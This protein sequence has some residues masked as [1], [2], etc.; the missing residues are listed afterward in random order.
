MDKVI[1]SILL[2]DPYIL[3]VVVRQGAVPCSPVKPMHTFSIDMLEL[4]RVA[5][6]RNPHFSIQ[7]FVKTLCDLQGVCIKSNK[8]CFIFILDIGGLS[9]IC[10][11]S[12]HHCT[13]SIPTNLTVCVGY[14]VNYNPLHRIPLAFEECMSCMHIYTTRRARTQILFTLHYGWQ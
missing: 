12:T 8:R 14:D 4:F 13:R 9:A 3:L 5:C 11:S 10:F 1:F 7:S 2:T 6:N